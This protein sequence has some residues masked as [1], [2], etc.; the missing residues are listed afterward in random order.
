MN[1]ANVCSCKLRA[2]DALGFFV[3]ITIRISLWNCEVGFT[4]KQMR[5]I[6]EANMPIYINTISI[7]EG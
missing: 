7:K 4:C 3:P 6:N 2:F 1:Q 5:Q